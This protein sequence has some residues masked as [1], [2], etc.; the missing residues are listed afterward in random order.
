MEAGQ[1]YCQEPQRG[2]LT[3][4]SVRFN[5]LASHTGRLSDERPY[6]IEVS[7]CDEFT[8]L[9]VGKVFVEVVSTICMQFRYPPTVGSLF[10]P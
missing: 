4:V 9:A 7:Y 5:H 2:V 6:A 10:V 3:C 1:E 8:S